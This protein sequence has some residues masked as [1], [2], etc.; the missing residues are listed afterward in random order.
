MK[1]LSII[2]R[3][4]MNHNKRKIYLLAGKAAIVSF[5]CRWCS[6]SGK[7]LSIPQS[8]ADLVLHTLG[9]DDQQAA[10]KIALP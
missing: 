6:N 3:F 2:T 4:E 8:M 9:G 10:L 7:W 5:S 1:K